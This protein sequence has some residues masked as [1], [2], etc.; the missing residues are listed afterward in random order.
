MPK[1]FECVSSGYTG[2]GN[3]GRTISVGFRPSLL[4]IISINSDFGCGVSMKTQ[5]MPDDSFMLPGYT[6]FAT[7]GVTLSDT[8]FSL[9]T[10]AGVN[11][12]NATYYYVAFY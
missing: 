1:P 3:S 5:G 10:A 12:L 9:G 2:D 11:Q 8:G 4:L 7:N 6:G